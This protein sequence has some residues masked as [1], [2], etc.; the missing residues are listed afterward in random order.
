[1]DNFCAVSVDALN[2]AARALLA[3]GDL[4]QHNGLPASIIVTTT[5]KELEAAAGTGLTG[6]GTLLP[7]SDVI[8]LARHAHHYLAIFD[9]GKALALYHTKRLAS[10][11]QRIVL[12]ANSCHSCA[13]YLN[14]PGQVAIRL[15][16]SGGRLRRRSYSKSGCSLAAF[17]S[18]GRTQQLR[19][20]ARGHG[21]VWR[22]DGSGRWWGLAESEMLTHGVGLE[23]V[24]SPPGQSDISSHFASWGNPH[25]QPCVF[26]N[27]YR[28]SGG[29]NVR[30]FE[31]G[32]PRLIGRYEG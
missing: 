5:L 30:I 24:I 7:M 8:R 25:Y 3:S 4:G 28:F 17:A 31:I 32:L 19:C 14:L 26:K 13:P 15:H 22:L 12:Y 23:G 21:S 9:N 6:G 10:P 1:M 29:P 20:R 27:L 18:G 16:S 11:G 2:A